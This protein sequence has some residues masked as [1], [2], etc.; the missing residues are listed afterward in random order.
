L[1]QEVF[2][3]RLVVC[4]D[5]TW[6][7][8]DSGAGET[9]VARMA[10]AVSAS[11]LDQG[12]AQLTLYLRGVGSTGSVVSRFVGGVTGD[13]VDENIRSAYMFI[14]Q[15]YVPGDQ[16]F[17]FGFSRGAFTARSL[18][19][20]IGSVGILKRWSLNK[21]AEAWGYYRRG[22]NRTS[23]EFCERT[24]GAACHGTVRVDFLGVWDTV[25]ALGVPTGLGEL[26]PE[27]Q[28]HDTSPSACVLRAR[29]ALAIDEHRDE[30]VP[31]FWTGDNPRDLDIQQVWFAG[32]HADIGGGYGPD[33]LADI[34][35]RWMAEEASRPIAGADGT[36][37]PGLVLDWDNV[38]PPRGDP[39][40]AQHESRQ[41]VFAKD[42][43]T[44]TYRRLCQ[45]DREVGR[46]SRLYVPS[47]DGRVLPTI[48]ESVHPSVWQ[49][50]GE[51][52]TLIDGMDLRS[53]L[54]RP[55]N[56]PPQGSAPT[57][58]APSP[59]THGAPIDDRQ[60]AE[61]PALVG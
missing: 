48:N 47:K 59:A 43:W 20:F 5:G 41:G 60:P 37:R 8:V 29:H 50:L 56:L 53:I 24:P 19:G 46:L 34:P 35:L 39:L 15:N 26:A 18:C 11:S 49:R 12:T 9:N 32:A 33:G 51:Q 30:F 45:I 21:V 36:E 38:L 17:V 13:G 61:G 23:Q 55:D 27:Y 7:S 3:K 54:Y 42:R 40:A 4:L 25:G 52:V 1:Q 6:N 16:I 44:P 28:F 57:W 22:G 14:A 2:M 31:T 58:T 10:R